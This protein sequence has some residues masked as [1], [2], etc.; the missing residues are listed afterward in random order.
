MSRVCDTWLRFEF[1][2]FNF[3]ILKWFE[4]SKLVRLPILEI[5][6]EIYI[7]VDDDLPFDSICFGTL[8]NSRKYIS[9]FWLKKKYV[10]LKRNNSL[11]S[12][13][14]L[15][16]R[17]KSVPFWLEIVSNKSHRF[18]L[19]WMDRQPKLM[20]H[21]RLHFPR[22]FLD[23][24]E[25]EK[26]NKRIETFNVSFCYYES[27]FSLLLSH[28]H[29]HIFQHQLNS[30]I[31]VQCVLIHSNKCQSW[32]IF[33]Q[34][35]QWSGLWVCPPLLVNCC[36]INLIQ[37]I[38]KVLQIHQHSKSKKKVTFFFLLFV[39]FVNFRV[40][41]KNWTLSIYWINTIQII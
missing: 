21:K 23:L 3:Y 11:Q 34:A 4:H 30:F 6:S 19:S 38:G 28:F 9:D 33:W 25:W 13:N 41:L 17:C 31:R 7:L 36:W 24:S 18:E 1:F 39:P 20:V 5:S 26:Q 15:H 27:A 14:H 2:C 10:D 29:W 40:F 22:L 8:V 16:K 32:Q 12:N 35:L 37:S